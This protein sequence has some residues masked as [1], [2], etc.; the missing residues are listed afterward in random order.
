M[1]INALEDPDGIPVHI[2]CGSFYQAYNPS[3]GY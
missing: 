1:T 3:E 2:H